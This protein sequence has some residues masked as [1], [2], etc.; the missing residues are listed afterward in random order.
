MIKEE[1]IKILQEI[2]DK[3]FE[4]EY[5][6]F[7][8]LNRIAK[9]IKEKYNVDP[10]FLWDKFPDYG[11]FRNRRSSKWFSIIMDIDKSKII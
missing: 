8:Q 2:K 9:K 11:V 7:N 10:E 4:K 6:I 5:F 1:Y 3:C